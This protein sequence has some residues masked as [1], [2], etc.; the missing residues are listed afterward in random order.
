M[1]AAV[2]SAVNVTADNKKNADDDPLGSILDDTKRV[3]AADRLAHAQVPQA[4][5]KSCWRRREVAKRRG[6]QAQQFVVNI[7]SHMRF[8]LT[9]PARRIRT[10]SSRKT[11]CS[12]S[13]FRTFFARNNRLGC[14]VDKLTR[15]API[16]MNHMLHSPP[17][18]RPRPLAVDRPESD[19][20]QGTTRPV[21]DDVRDDCCLLCW[22]VAS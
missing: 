14:T 2:D 5:L 19:A 8:V 3:Q 18:A 1:R 20:A 6:A 17:Q 13:F 10:I 22:D 11:L 21:R 15:C 16:L 7:C 9:K 4:I 12:I